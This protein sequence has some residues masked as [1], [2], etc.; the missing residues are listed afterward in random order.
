MSLVGG[1]SGVRASVDDPRHHETGGFILRGSPE[2]EVQ[3][4]SEESLG[5]GQDDDVVLDKLAR[6]LKGDQT[7]ENHGLNGIGQCLGQHAVQL[8]MVELM[9]HGR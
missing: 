1:D 5:P 4:G 3:F 9:I 8:F 7:L 2:Q 6:S